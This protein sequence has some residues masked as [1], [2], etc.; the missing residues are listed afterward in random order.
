[1]RPSIVEAY[2]SEPGPEIASGYAAA[3]RQKLFRNP[4][5][6]LGGN[7]K[8]G[9]S[10]PGH[11]HPDQGA[12]GIH[13][14]AALQARIGR[15]PGTA[16]PIKAPSAFTNGP[17]SRRGSIDRSKRIER[18]ICPPRRLRQAPPEDATMARPAI[19]PSNLPMTT[20]SSPGRTSA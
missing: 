3:V 7:G 11:G 8:R 6:R 1:M 17:P 16:I 10:R 15:G 20:A 14:R 13:Q 18:S 12:L 19:E 9:P 5:Y 4:V 2:G